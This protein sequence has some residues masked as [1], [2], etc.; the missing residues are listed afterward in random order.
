MA[1]SALL[2]NIKKHVFEKKFCDPYVEILK[3]TVAEIVSDP[4]KFNDY[5]KLAYIMHM[6]RFDLDELTPENMDFSHLK[7]YRQDLQSLSTELGIKELGYCITANE[8]EKLF[9]S[10]MKDN[11]SFENYRCIHGL[12]D[13]SSVGSEI[14]HRV[15]C[16][17]I[18]PIMSSCDGIPFD[19]E[20]VGCSSD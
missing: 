13:K 4:A 16:D 7:S 9:Y 10:A 18:N 11:E 17:N 2:N 12:A 19:Y 5:P 6:S 1:S 3:S 8:P 15:D 14:L 20:M